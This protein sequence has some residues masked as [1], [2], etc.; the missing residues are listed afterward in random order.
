[1]TPDDPN[2]PCGTV[3]KLV[4]STEL[5][6]RALD[7]SGEDL[8]TGERGELL[9]R[10]PQVMRGYFARPSETDAMIDEDGWL[11]TGD[12]GYLDERGYLF[13]VDR[14]KELIKY[15]G[16]QVAPA[17]LEALLLAHPRIAD[18]AV[19]GVTGEDGVERPKAYVVRTPGSALTGEEVIHYVAGQVAPYKKVRAV[20]FLDAVPKSV[21]GK[22]LRRELRDRARQTR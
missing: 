6:V 18:A 15:K 21:S 4:P 5:R 9:F 1:M 14:V 7:G 3:G 10:G 2:P 16:Y 12:I 13:V 19:I 8:G 20:E 11:H 17:E 22:I